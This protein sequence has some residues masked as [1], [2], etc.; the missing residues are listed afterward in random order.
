MFDGTNAE[1]GDFAASANLDND[2]FAQLVQSDPAAAARILQRAAEHGDAIAQALFAQLLLDGNGV[3]RDR[4]MAWHWFQLAAHTGHVMA[5]NM[6]G[7]CCEFGW[8]RAIDIELAAVWYRRAADHGL[9][10]GMYNLAHL[11]V[12]GSGVAMDRSLAYALYRRAAD[13]GHAKS[14]G[15]VG[16]YHEQGWE[17]PA[18]ANAAFDWY[19]K[20]AHGGD[21]RGQCSYASLL[22]QRGQ[23]EDAVYWLRLAVQ[24]AIPSFAIKLAETLA[25]SAQAEFRKIA[26]EIRQCHTGHAVMAA[27]L[28]QALHTAA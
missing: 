14:M 10:W 7:R 9:D 24:T 8:G 15:I 1:L 23:I 5:M 17:V 11:H 27:D 6:L 22:A 20:S 12:S 13:L 4:E 21:F 19:R 3:M 2:Q 16:R 25:V 28:E 26:L 18:D